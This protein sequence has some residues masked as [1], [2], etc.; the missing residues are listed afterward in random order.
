M[1]GGKIVSVRWMI[2]GQLRKK[3]KRAFFVAFR[4][5]ACVRSIRLAVPYGSTVDGK[6]YVAVARAGGTAFSKF[7]I[8]DCGVRGVVWGRTFH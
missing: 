7:G 1:G 8:P 5:R 6:Q 2:E 4:V 3:K